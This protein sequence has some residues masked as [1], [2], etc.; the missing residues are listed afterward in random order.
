[1]DGRL[2]IKAISRVTAGALL[3]ALL[4]FV[5]A[6]TINYQ[7]GWLLMAILFIPMFI[8][9][10]YMNGHNFYKSVKKAANF[11]SECISY[12]EENDIPSNWGLP[13]EMYLKD[14]MD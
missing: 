9:G 4:I 12:C 2:F 11:A 6:G 8:A 13:F 5:P 10:M 1:M 7:N 14:L 3:V